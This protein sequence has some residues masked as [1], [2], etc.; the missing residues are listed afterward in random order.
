MMETTQQNIAEKELFELAQKKV[1]KIKNFYIHLFVYSIAITFW[2]LKRYTDLPLNFFP[3][4][5][6]N[7]LVMSIWTAVIALQAIGLIINE[8][9]FGRKWEDKQVKNMLK[10]ESKKQTWE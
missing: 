4:R 7:W 2:L 10:E 5:H 6:F 1:K 8:V 3:I 9:I